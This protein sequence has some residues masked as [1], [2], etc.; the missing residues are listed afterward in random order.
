[1]LRSI[2]AFVAVIVLW[3]VFD[4]VRAVS[5]Q[6]AT[7]LHITLLGRATTPSTLA[8][9]LAVASSVFLLTRR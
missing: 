4:I 8:V 2:L 5:K 3:A 6:Y 1:M 9:G 7:S